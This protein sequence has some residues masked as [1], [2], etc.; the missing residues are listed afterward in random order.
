MRSLTHSVHI[1]GIGRLDQ[2]GPN[3]GFVDGIRGEWFALDLVQ[4]QSQIFL[5]L[6]ITVNNPKIFP[7]NGRFL[8]L[9]DTGEDSPRTEICS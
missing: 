8:L 1:T 9:K 3:L 4:I 5:N 2:F 7:Q 6:H